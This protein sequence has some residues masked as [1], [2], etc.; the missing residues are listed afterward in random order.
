MTTETASAPE[1]EQDG[2]KDTK[3]SKRSARGAKGATSAAKAA[4]G[5]DGDAFVPDLTNHAGLA[6]AA[7]IRV[8]VGI[9]PN[10]PVNQFD[11]AGVT[12]VKQTERLVK[13]PHDDRRKMRIP[14]QGSIA[15]LDPDRLGELRDK[16]SRTV[17][18]MQH[19]PEVREEPGTGTNV[20]DPMVR[21]SRGFAITIPT[22]EEVRQR[23]ELGLPNTEY[24]H[25][26]QRDVPAA[27][28]LYLKVCADQKNGLPEAIIPDPIAVTGI[29]LPEAHEPPA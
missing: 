14:Q 20:G 7:P 27:K 16:L 29:Q 25:D 13:D 2:A 21:E 3:P 24:R 6:I 9:D 26:P 23:R 12:F 22:S 28:F 17:V 8:W 10:C 18:R 5:F 11:L 4:T 1:T 19:R 15:Y